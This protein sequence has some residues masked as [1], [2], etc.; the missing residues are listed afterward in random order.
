METVATQLRND[1]QQ[2]LNIL[3]DRIANAYTLLPSHEDCRVSDAARKAYEE[4]YEQSRREMERENEE[5][6]RERAEQARLELWTKKPITENGYIV[7]FDV[8]DEYGV[9]VRREEATIVTK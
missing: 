7:A 5:R 2:A 4:A 3:N 8:F 9:K 6:E 1:V